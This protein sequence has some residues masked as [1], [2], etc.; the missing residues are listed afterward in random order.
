MT[1]E[2][3]GAWR[4]TGTPGGSTQKAFCENNVGGDRRRLET[5]PESHGLYSR[6][7]AKQLPACGDVVSP[8]DRTRQEVFEKLFKCHQ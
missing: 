8:K 7:Y 3:E 6:G 1:K 5:T 4:R 2:S